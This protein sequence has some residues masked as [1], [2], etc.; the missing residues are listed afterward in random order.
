MSGVSRSLTRAATRFGIAASALSLVGL[1]L[2]IYLTVEHYSS[3]PSYLCPANSVLNCERVTE[4]AYA[5]FAGVPVAVLGIVYFVASVPLHLPVAWR[6]RNLHL[7]RARW[8][9]AAVGMVAVFWLIWGEL[10]VGAIC[11]YC[12]GVHL[13]T[14]GLLVLTAIGSAWL[15]PEED[16]TDDP[17]EPVAVPS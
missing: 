2:S 7:E 3:S 13:A 16:P 4:S 14:F 15:T 10:E 12:T 6:A 1:G 9:W 8:A 5:T 11:V 17:P